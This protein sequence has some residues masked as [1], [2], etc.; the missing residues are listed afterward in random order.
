MEARRATARAALQPAAA[1]VEEGGNAAVRAS[2]EDGEVGRTEALA[3]M[4]AG[5]TDAAD[6]AAA[7]GRAE[8]LE[9]GE[10]EPPLTL[11]RLMELLG[12]QKY[13][14]LLQEEELDLEVGPLEPV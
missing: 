14:A 8:G 4:A 9:E 13:T 11:E 3:A 10:A 6:A 1:G 5:A 7:E 2:E 12:L